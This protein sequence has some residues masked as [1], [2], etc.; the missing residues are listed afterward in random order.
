MLYTP[1]LPFHNETLEADHTPAA[2]PIDGLR[3]YLT[4]VNNMR[5]STPESVSAWNAHRR[6]A[7][8]YG[9][10]L[11]SQITPEDLNSTPALEIA[12]FAS[13]TLPYNIGVY[14]RALNVSKARLVEDE[15]EEFDAAPA[16]PS[17][18]RLAGFAI[19][20]TA[21]RVIS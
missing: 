1:E 16:K 10:D 8:A 13:E 9:A 17:L 12:D 18:L 3:G 19:R 7:D 6:T 21:F 20:R 5:I 15:A 11:L 4:Y 14:Y 2:N